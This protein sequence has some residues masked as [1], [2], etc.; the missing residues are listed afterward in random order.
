MP[1]GTRS[2]LPGTFCGRAAIYHRTR[3][4]PLSDSRRE[5]GGA[6]IP[7][8]PAGSGQNRSLAAA[9]TSGDRYAAIRSV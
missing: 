6:S 7:V 9:Q 8:L 5:S 1:P 4:K 2:R 3:R